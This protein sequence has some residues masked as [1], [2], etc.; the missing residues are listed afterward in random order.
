[1]SKQDN[2][3][4]LH[5]R[6]LP[7][8]LDYYANPSFLLL[9][10]GKRAEAASWFTEIRKALRGVEISFY[11]MQEIIDENKSGS[12]I[13]TEGE[14]VNSIYRSDLYIYFVDNMIFRIFSVRE[15]L[16]QMVRTHY[17]FNSPLIVSEGERKIELTVRT[18]TF[19][20]L[21]CSLKQ[22]P[23]DIAIDTH[24]FK[25]QDNTVLQEL[26][27]YRDGFTHH[28]NIIDQTQGIPFDVEVNTIGNEVTTVFTLQGRPSISDL[29]IKCVEAYNAIVECID[30]FDE[31]I[32]P[33]D[34]KIE[35]K[36]KN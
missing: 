31:I 6:P 26:K 20:K 34:F 3:D 16:S 19:T 32:F 4:R 21:I 13:P 12:K 27:G 24:L 9:R 22:S 23:R 2:K 17:E 25:L 10:G 35:I 14:K 7:Q 18:C 36:S 15:K 1:M 28:N 8:D 29:R 5:L 11:W 33:R 30:A